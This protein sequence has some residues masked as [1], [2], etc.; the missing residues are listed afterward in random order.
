LNANPELGFIMAGVSAGANLSAV[1]SLLARDSNL[2]PP[3]TGAFLS[4]LPAFHNDSVPEKYKS[5]WLSLEQNGVTDPILS[6]A[7][8]DY[9]K[10]KFLFYRSKN[11]KITMNQ[12]AL[13]A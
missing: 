10:G 3:L 2:T 6:R 12:R 9:I 1:L 11:P 5:R 7:M 4:A 13:Q 8:Y